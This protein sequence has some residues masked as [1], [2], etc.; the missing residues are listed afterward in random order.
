MTV[1]FA[2]IPA[3][4]AA[5]RPKAD[6]WHGINRIDEYG[7]LRADNWQEVFK[8]P[9][10]LD[11]AIRSHLEAENAYQTAMMADTAE[12][13][14]KLFL[15]MRGRIKEDDSSVPMKDGPFAYGTSFKA[16][17]EQPR[18]FR[19]PRD[20][21]EEQILLDGDKEAEGKGYFRLGGADHSP[22]HRLLL[23]G[24]DDKGSEF[25]TLH[26]RDVESGMDSADSVADTGGAGTW[27]AEAAGFFYTC[28]DAN[29]R[30]SRIYY[31]MLGKKRDRLIYEE[32]DPGFFMDVGGT[33]TNRWIMI[34]IHDHETSEYH[35]LPANDPGAKPHLVAA[36]ETGLQY[37]LEDGG[38]VFFI[39]TNADGA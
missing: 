25:Y 2:D 17:G 39:L 35:I 32:K 3:P 12:L 4:Q 10:L 22:D 8:D 30:P 14:K 38:D 6:N 9:S 5:M 18:F 31:H 16:G 24:F 19:A 11:P 33:L 15:E 26:V 29:H 21:G 27:D 20:G 1:K 13:Q 23:W 7:W 37:D 36:R 28:L 34:A